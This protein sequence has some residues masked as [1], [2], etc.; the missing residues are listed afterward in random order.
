MYADLSLHPLSE[1]LVDVAG[2]L[3]H[4]SDFGNAVA[5]KLSGI[6]K[7][8]PAFALRGAVSNS[9]RAPSLSQVSYKLTSTSF[10]DG[11]ALAHVLT[12]PVSSPIA[13][14]LGAQDLQAPRNRSTGAVVSPWPGPSTSA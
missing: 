3:E 12:L 9:F 4:Y 2:R 5:G 8:T 10:G 7:I 1:L 6:Y 13:R 14:A 11:G